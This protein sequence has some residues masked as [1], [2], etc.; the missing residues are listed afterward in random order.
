LYIYIYIY[1]HIVL[2]YN[3]F[4][5]VLLSEL[6]LEKLV[7]LQLVKSRLLILRNVKV[8]S[9]VH[10]RLSLLCIL[11]HMNAAHFFPSYF[12]KIHFNITLPPNPNTSKWSLILRLLQKF[13]MHFFFFFPKPATSCAYFFLLD[14]ATLITFDY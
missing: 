4:V 3:T 14:S 7:V 10:N 11:S 8:Y 9:G 6:L 5:I 2:T 1:T 12:F 13:F